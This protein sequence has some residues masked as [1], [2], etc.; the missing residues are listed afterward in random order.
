MTDSTNS[1]DLTPDT[2]PQWPCRPLSAD[3]AWLLQDDTAPWPEPQP[4][5]PCPVTLLPPAE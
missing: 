4:P 2:P 1:A 5:T 3:P